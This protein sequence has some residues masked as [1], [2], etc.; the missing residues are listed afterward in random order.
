MLF[1]NKNK[2]KNTKNKKEGKEEKQDK[3]SFN[4]KTPLVLPK[5]SPQVMETFFKEADE[6]S[7]IMRIDDIRYSVCYE[8]TDISFSKAGQEEQ[9]SIFL[10]YVKFLNSHSVNEHIQIVHTGTIV[11]TEDY[12]SKFIYQYED[13]QTENEKKLTN[14]FNKLITGVIGHKNQTLCETRLIV[15]TL[16][17]ESLEEAKDLF[18][19]YQLRLEEQFK[20]FGSKV[21]KW[22]IQERLELLYNTFHLNTLEQD[23]HKNGN[24]INEQTNSDLCIYDVLAPKED[25]NFREKN[26][27]SIGDKK[28]LRVMYV[29]K[30]PTS[31]TPEFYNNLTTIEDANIIVTE[32]INGT[33]PANVIKRL[34]KKISGMKDERLAKIKRANKNHYDYA[35][36]KDEKLEERLADALALRDALT[37]KK[38]KLFTKNILICIIANDLKE[39]KQVTQ[40]INKISSESL[41]TTRNLDWQQLEGMMNV[42]PFGFNTLQFQRSLTSE[43]TATS[44]P[45]NTKQLLHEKALFYG[46]DM[47][48]KNIVFADRKKLMNGNG[49][50]L[51]TSGSGKSFFVKTNIEQILLRY[52]NDDII[53]VDY[54]KEY[55]KIINDFEGQ[56]IKIATGAETYI[57]PFDISLEYV[58]EDEDPIKTKMEYVLAF[59]ESIIGGSGLTGEQKSII[60]RCSKILYEDYLEH[61]NDKEYEPNFLRFY[62]LLNDNQEIE[63]KNLKLI[64]ERYVKGSMDI[65]AKNTNVSINNRL[66]SFDL[67]KLPKSMKTTGYLVVLEH[68]MNKISQNRNEGKNTW[69]FVDEFHIMLD[70]KFSADYIEKIYRIARKYGALPTIITQKIEDV[71]RCVQGRTILS[72][73]EFAAILKQRALDLQPICE[74]FGISEEEANYVIDSPPGQGLIIYGEDIVAFKLKVPEDYYI[75]E[76]N[77][78]SNLQKARG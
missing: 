10:K 45:F 15:I 74:I 64:L 49:A 52:P 63:A 2:E 5:I 17:A 3:K 13:N 6:E 55:E 34:N 41:V 4:K 71:L 53:I 26:Y 30:L 67:S 68:I 73:S 40:K 39:L 59:I 42:L 50:V 70:N 21:R 22:S 24:L 38:Q 14:E 61:P 65:F 76:L 60:D 7:G 43:A 58:D 57:N 47:V 35:A 9:E 19:A 51:A 18:M 29:D 12:K 48:S 27:I 56:T 37:K 78:T 77:Q 16:E 28:Y 69:I 8:Y 11:E 44:V 72:N 46:V 33:D 36:V 1:K 23:F 25:I 62:K 32:N 54:Q 66:V 31:I 75:Y 20:S